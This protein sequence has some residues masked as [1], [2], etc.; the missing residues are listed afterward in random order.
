VCSGVSQI[1]SDSI[2]YNYTTTS[3]KLSE[4]QIV[5]CDTDDGVEGCDGGYT[6]GVFDYAKDTGLVSEDDYP[7]TS[8]WDVT[9]T[10][11]YSSSTMTSLVGVSEYTT[12]TGDSSTEIE[13]AMMSHIVS[14]G[15]LS[16]CVVAWEWA[17]YESG[18][19]SSCDS[20]V[21]DV[22]HCVQ[23][24]G[25]EAA[26]TSARGS[27]DAYWIIR[28]SWGEYWGVEGYLYLKYVSCVNDLS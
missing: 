13:T 20:D 8:Y 16:I 25:Y 2:R 19:L 5:S 6:E 26:T 1:E 18:I 11:T 17:S 10:C 4:Q 24:V 15:P 3:Q 23:L 14:T 28:N 7:Y 21:D 22:D 12:I 9:G 27:T